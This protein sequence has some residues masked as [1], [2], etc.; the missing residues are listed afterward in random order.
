MTVSQMIQHLSELQSEHGDVNVLSYNEREELVDVHKIDV[1]V[2]DGRNVRTHM[3][4]DV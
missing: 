3:V 2:V 4:I 1:Y